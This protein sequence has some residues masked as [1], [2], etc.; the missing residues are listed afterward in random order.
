MS[1]LR[2]NLG[3][4]F[5]LTVPATQTKP[6]KTLNRFFSYVKVF[7]LAVCCLKPLAG[8]S[9]CQC[10]KTFRH[11]RWGKNKLDRFHCQVFHTSLTFRPALT[12]SMSKLQSLPKIS[13]LA[14]KNFAGWNTPDYFA[15]PSLTKKKKFYNIVICLWPGP[16]TRLCTCTSVWRGPTTPSARSS[17]GSTSNTPPENFTSLSTWPRQTAR[18]K[19][20]RSIHFPINGFGKN[21]SSQIWFTTD[22]LESNLIKLYETM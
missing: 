18:I 19:S 13:R 20:S 4:A 21:E 8:V 22:L 16:S 11:W 5:S 17:S 3:R 6:A 14:W 10:Y 7:W 2:L 9:W 15:M 12:H 1:D